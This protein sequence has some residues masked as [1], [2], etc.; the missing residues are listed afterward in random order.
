MKRRKFFKKFSVLCASIFLF[1]KV[2]AKTCTTTWGIKTQECT[3]CEKCVDIAPNDFELEDDKATFRTGCCLSD[4]G[5]SWGDMAIAHGAMSA[6]ME[7]ARDSC[8][9]EAIVEAA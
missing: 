4:A 2:S 7:N 8:P 6:H 5:G 1:K 9:V 3:G